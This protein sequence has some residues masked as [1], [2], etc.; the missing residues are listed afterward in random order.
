MNS[1]VIISLF[2]LTTICVNTTGFAQ[3]NWE[4]FPGNPVLDVGPP[5][6]WEELGVLAL[7]VLFDGTTYHIWYTGLDSNFTARIGYATSLDGT[8]W[9][10]FAGN[11]ILCPIGPLAN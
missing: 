9:T 5:G 10:K 4:K 11:P 8:N 7:W 3:T 1:I 6:T 2:L